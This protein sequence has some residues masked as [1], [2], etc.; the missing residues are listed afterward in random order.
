MSNSKSYIKLLSKGDIDNMLPLVF[1]LNKAYEES[2][3]RI[4]LE[5][6][7]NYETYVCF[8]LFLEEQLIGITSGWTAT[9]LYSG[10]QLEID[11]VIVDSEFQSN[12]YGKFME[13]AIVIWCKERNYN[14]VELNTYVKNSGSHKF[15][16]NQGYKIIGYHFEKKL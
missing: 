4:Y 14:S 13:K 1:Q 5:E 3:M 9:K 15:Y 2:Q 11:N 12:G 8:G 6:M 10:K 16:F 7:F